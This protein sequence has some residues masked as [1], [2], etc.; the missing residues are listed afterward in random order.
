[1][2][3]S[4]DKPTRLLLSAAGFVIVVAGMRAAGSILVPF[5]LAAFLAVICAPPVFWLQR[6]RVPA[7]LAVAIVAAGILAAE[8]VV[9]ALVGASID[10]F[11]RA[12]PGYQMRL[13]EEM[14][15]LLG[16]LDRFGIDAPDRSL[17]QQID[18]GA[19]MRLV[20]TMLSGFG[21][22]LA[23]TFLILLAVIFM[24]LE[25]SG[26][27][28]KVHAA[29]GAGDAVLGPLRRFADSLKSYLAIKT[30]V[31]LLTGVSAALALWLLGIDFPLLWGLLAFLLNYVPNIGSIIAAV[32]PALLGWIQFGLG[33]ALMVA[34]VFLVINIIYGNIIEPKFMGR[35]L[36]LSTLVV[37]VS[38]VFW[39]WV[40][41]PVGMLLSVPLTMSV[42]IALETNENT[43]WAAVLLEGQPSAALRECEAEPAKG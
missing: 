15:G 34:A 9:A 1:M 27:P 20:A 25:A 3:V 29:F 38:L 24:L 6:R 7:P 21:G 36:G 19:V 16:L 14:V 42:K 30:V 13:Q 35:G 23:N 5:L 12:L 22:V 2:N 40:F 26:F 10:D 8:L 32:P 39:G 4:L 28:A 31:S 41:G 43:R 11:Y 18:P 33:R 17:I 37:F